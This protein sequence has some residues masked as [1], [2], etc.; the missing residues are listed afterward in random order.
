MPIEY[1]IKKGIQVS[2]R[3]SE[4]PQGAESVRTEND[5]GE[6]EESDWGEA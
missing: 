6:D 4:F 2:A 1:E 3:V 5:E